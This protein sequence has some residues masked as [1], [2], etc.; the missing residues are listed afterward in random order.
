MCTVEADPRQIEQL[1]INLIGNALKF[2]R[3]GIPPVVDVSSRAAGEMCEIRVT[4]NG[5][6]FDSAHADRIFD[7][8]ERLHARH[9]YGGTGIGLAI[10]KKI[11]ER[12]GG[13]IKVEAKPD[14]GATFIIRLPMHQKA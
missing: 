10:C 1:F 5:I 11:A 4:D 7:V 8:F 14:E 6:G 2:H 3:E 13:N 9:K 12:H